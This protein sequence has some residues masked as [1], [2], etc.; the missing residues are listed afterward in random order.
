MKP[1]NNSLL[2]DIVRSI[3]YVRRKFK[4]EFIKRLNLVIFVPKFDT[5]SLNIELDPEHVENLN[6]DRIIYHS[7]KFEFG[8]TKVVFSCF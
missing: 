8:A 2:E 3:I 7:N 4:I 1:E 6:S 5:R